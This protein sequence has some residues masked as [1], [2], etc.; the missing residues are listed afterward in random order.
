MALGKVGQK[1]L[2][3]ESIGD[4]AVEL[5]RLEDGQYMAC[6]DLKNAS[7]RSGEQ[8]DAFH[9][10]LELSGAKPKYFILIH[11]SDVDYSFDAQRILWNLPY[12]ERV[13]FIIQNH[14]LIG[15]VDSIKLVALRKDIEMGCFYN[16]EEAEDWI[17]SCK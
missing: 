6:M 2:L 17:K 3:D 4:V 16:L 5:W 13:A 12:I 14:I 8:V 9:K 7:S 15:T 1:Q 10:I 11:D